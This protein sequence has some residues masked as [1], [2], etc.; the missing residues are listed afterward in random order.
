M[1][2]RRG[3]T[4]QLLASAERETKMQAKRQQA[5]AA[6]A[7]K[8]RQMHAKTQQHMSKLAREVA[9]RKKGEERNQKLV[10]ILQGPQ[11]PGD[12]LRAVSEERAAGLV[13]KPWDVIAAQQP[14]PPKQ[15]PKPIPRGY[16][17]NPAYSAEPIRAESPADKREAEPELVEPP[18]AVERAERPVTPL[19]P[20]R[21]AQQMEQ[22][23]PAAMETRTF[24]KERGVVHV[25]PHIRSPSLELPSMS[26]ERVAPLPPA[27]AA[28]TLQRR[29][30]APMETKQFEKE[31][32]PARKRE[33]YSPGPHLPAPSPPLSPIQMADP[34]GPRKRSASRQAMEE[35]GLVQAVVTKAEKDQQRREEE[36]EHKE[37]LAK[38]AQKQPPKR[39]TVKRRYG[40]DPV[41]QAPVAVE[42]KQRRVMKRRTGAAP[43]AERKL[44][45]AEQHAG[46]SSQKRTGTAEV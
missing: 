12:V 5:Q 44:E 39:K 23:K 37:L 33:V 40:D 20:A 27:R 31:T 22:R 6:R 15:Q 35:K 18:K 19:G 38:L 8:Q 3:M 2:H 29:E 36:Q 32:R 1:P 10:G 11:G 41:E 26:P 30:T 7:E 28:Q 34:D 24:E 16:L 17:T 9:I 25:K 45:Q 43:P 42:P 14:R 21:P 46:C 13:P 4:P